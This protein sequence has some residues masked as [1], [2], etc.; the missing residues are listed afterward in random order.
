MNKK[1]LPIGISDFKTLIERNY[2][3]ADKSLLIKELL[4]SGAAATLIPRPRRFGK[5]LNL[6]LL[7]YFFEK[8]DESN[9]HLFKDM[10][11]AKHS[12][13]M[14]H[15]G[16][17]P[18]IFMTF[19]DVKVSS[20]SE[21]WDA[22]KK[23][24]SAEFK[25]H[26]YLLESNIFKGNEKVSF[27]EICNET[28]Q[29]VH[30][31]SSLVDLSAYLIRFY[32]QKPIILIDE[33]DAPIHAGYLNNYYDQVVGFIRNF[34]SGG[35]KDNSNL[36]FAV[37]TGI[38]RIA[39]ESIFSG[40]NNLKV[41]SLRDERY[42]DKFGLTEAEV[43]K[44][45][46]TYHPTIALDDV[47]DW[48]DGYMSGSIKMY[49]PWSIINFAD[50]GNLDPYWVNTSDNVLIK[51]IIAS[52]SVTFKK[53]C[54]LLLAGKAVKQEIRD[55][56]A[57]PEIKTNAETLW[58]FL[59]LCGYVTFDTVIRED[60]SRFSHFSIPNKEVF[61]LYRTIIKKWLEEAL[62]LATY[63][64]MLSHLTSGNTVDFKKMFKRFAQES[65][66]S[67]DVGGKE[68]EKFYHALV[69]GMF[70]NL[71]TTHIIKSNRESGFGR[72]D[73]MLIPH[74]KTKH[75]I[76]IE[77]KK[78]DID[79]NETLETAAQ[80]ALKQIADKKYVTELETLCIKQIIKLAIVFEGKDVLVL[81][82]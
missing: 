9:A 14:E 11:I 76:V 16:K 48:Y 36:Q 44:I 65:L 33:Y 52:S 10:A 77:F 82:G 78:V 24:I 25:R 37:M 40:L 17:Y 57:F 67:F 66:S 4:D 12:K 56:V 6:S 39:K 49:N 45:V 15:Q 64:L 58:S 8:T 68:P 47:R 41:C 43:K 46:E 73:V 23:I 3:Y 71:H 54:E 80:N 22:I 2:Y 72:Y 28:A 61:Y 29:L 70:A 63:Q 18:V 51:Q 34:L 42:S 27:Q 55:D 1:M 38:L 53:D 69:L 75:G 59:F 31:S 7:Q 79:D 30:Y 13:C 21:C 62:S 74:D 81:E 35:L 20:W 26:D 50:T 32:K 19:K 5:T 60:V